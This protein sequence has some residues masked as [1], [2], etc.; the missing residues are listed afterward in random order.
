MQP[1]HPN[2]HSRPHS[3]SARAPGPDGPCGGLGYQIGLL[4]GE[5]VTN[6][7]IGIVRIPHRGGQAEPRL[8]QGNRLVAD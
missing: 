2:P 7:S 1:V 3:C 5:A 6:T 8:Q 4:A